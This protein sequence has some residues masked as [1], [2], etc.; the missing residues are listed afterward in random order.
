MNNLTAILTETAMKPF[1][2]FLAKLRS[3][4][5]LFGLVLIGSTIVIGIVLALKIGLGIPSE[6]LTRDPDALFDV[7]LYY[8]FLS[9]VGIFF[10]AASAAIC[11][12]S[13][14]LLS[15]APANA[16]FK[17][18]FLASGMLSLLLG[19]DDAFMLHE[20]F[21]PFIGIKEKLIYLTYIGLVL[22]YLVRFHAFIFT[23]EFLVLVVGLSLF[24]FSVAFDWFQPKDID[25]FF[26]E[27]GAKFIGILCWFVYFLH[28]SHLQVC[29]QTAQS[30]ELQLSERTRRG[31][32]DL[33]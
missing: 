5:V 15:S 18:F 13:Y 21:F 20:Q 27:D 24:A 29:R 31:S 4:S 30:A 17:K 11:I 8:G 2:Y 12:Y 14:S 19:I 23:T 6:I 26:Y 1:S 22:F 33:L 28:T 10:W 16:E 9:Q 32:T 7:P 3:S 25:I